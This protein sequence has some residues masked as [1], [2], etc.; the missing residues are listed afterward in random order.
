MD[1]LSTLVLAVSLMIIMFGMGLSLVVDDFKRIFTSPKAILIGLLN[2]L[3]LLPIVGFLLVKFIAVPVEIAV[4]VIIL[5]AC[6]GGATS[7]LI[8]HLAKGDTALSVSLTAISS[9]LTLFT[10]PFVINIG[11]QMVLG[12]STLIQLDVVQTILQVFAIAIIPVVLG[13]L[14]RAKREAFAQRMEKVARTASAVV[15][16]LVL[17]GVILKEIDHLV[18]YFQQAG[19][20]AFILNSCTMLLGLGVARVA[21][22]S[23]RQG[24]SISIESGIQNGTLAITIATLLLHNTSYAIAPAVYSLIMFFTGGGIIFWSLRQKVVAE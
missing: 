5:A 8:T 18:P 10:I 1:N 3:I 22:L 14:V 17:L 15:F 13:M 2:Q 7:N 23:F 4:G 19:I 11:L 6:P 24:V 21:K 16:A 12:R 20:I 9:F